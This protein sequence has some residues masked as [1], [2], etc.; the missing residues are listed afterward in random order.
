MLP[1]IPVQTFPVAMVTTGGTNSPGASFSR[2]HCLDC[3]CPFTWAAPS[4][5]K[6]EIITTAATD[7]GLVTVTLNGVR[8]YI[9]AKAPPSSLVCI[10]ENYPGIAVS[11]S[12]AIQGAVG[13]ALPMDAQ[14][15]DIDLNAT[16][17]GRTPL[18]VRTSAPVL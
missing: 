8:P 14:E 10:L 6:P 16:I 9:L 1:G 12:I 13:S 17:S 2:V 5:L 7:N 3:F 18:N 11:P 15:T 4:P